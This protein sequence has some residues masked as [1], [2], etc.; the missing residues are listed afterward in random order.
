MVSCPYRMIGRV[1]RKWRQERVVATIIVSFWEF[2]TW[3]GLVVPDS[4][5][6]AN[7]VVDW[8]WLDRRDPDLFVHGSD[9]GGRAAVPPVWPLLAIRVDFSE[10]GAHR[11]IPLSDRCLSG[12][13]GVCRSKSWHR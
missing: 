2:T 3:W 5:H 8:V 9:P 12:G 10:D 13:C 11:R 7:E 1:W 4:D 6:L